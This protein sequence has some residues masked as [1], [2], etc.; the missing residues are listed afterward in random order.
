MRLGLV[1]VAGLIVAAGAQAQAAGASTAQATKYVIV[2]EGCPGQLK[3]RT[4]TT[5]AGTVL[6]TTALEDKDKKDPSKAPGSMGVHV[7]FEGVRVEARSVELRVSYLS[8]GMR[9]MPVTPGTSAKEPQELKKTFAL[10]AEDK[11]R[12]EGDLMVGPASMIKDVHLISVTF[13]DGSVWRAP[14]DSACT[15][16]PNRVLPVDTK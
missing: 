9:V 12:V 1:A 6:W 5:G 2:G 15:I 14:N 13:A 16:E 3:A 10:A 4:A 11:D 7:E 8:P